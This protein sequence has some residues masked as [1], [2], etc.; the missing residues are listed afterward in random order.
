MI[1]WNGI[2]SINPKTYR[3]F[4][5][6]CTPQINIKTM[7]HELIPTLRLV[8]Y[9]HHNRIRNMLIY[10][11]P[12][13]YITPIRSF[14]P[15][16][17]MYMHGACCVCVKVMNKCFHVFRWFIWSKE[18]FRWFHSLLV[19]LLTCV[20]LFFFFL[21]WCRCCCCCAPLPVNWFTSMLLTAYWPT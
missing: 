19:S 16:I 18:S 8:N 3:Y 6:K 17:W 10:G 15:T 1:Q 20:C 2:E 7:I 11:F 14:W 21:S 13:S 4:G 5:H 12:K 9:M